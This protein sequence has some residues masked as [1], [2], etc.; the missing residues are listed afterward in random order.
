MQQFLKRKAEK[1]KLD[2]LKPFKT[3]GFNGH[4]VN[5]WTVI[6]YIP[7]QVMFD[8]IDVPWDAT[9]SD[10]EMLAYKFIR[11][12]LENRQLGP[13]YEMLAQVFGSETAEQMRGSVRGAW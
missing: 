7:V 5:G 1:R 12:V 10:L 11:P 3:M 6:R 2:L 9:V 13:A 8:Y 4:E